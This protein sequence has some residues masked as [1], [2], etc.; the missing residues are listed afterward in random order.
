MP[1]IMLKKYL[2]E[3]GMLGFRILTDNEISKNNLLSFLQDNKYQT[4]LELVDNYWIIGVNT[5]NETNTTE[6]HTIRQNNINKG[7]VFVITSNK[8]GEGNEE[9][10]EILMKGLFNSLTEMDNYPDK[11]I[12]YNSGAFL[13]IDSSPVIKSLNKLVEYGVDI[14]I[15]GACVDFYQLKDQISIGSITNMYSICEIL[16]KC[17]KVV[18]P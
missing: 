17:E 2:K 15:C 13:C 8:M 7:H 9:L 3:E 16:T 10:G 6:I 5:G 1:I 4:V 12:F 18:Y 11:I 14:L